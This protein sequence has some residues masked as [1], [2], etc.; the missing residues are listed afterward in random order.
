MN[1]IS[2]GSGA[3]PGARGRRPGTGDRQ[4]REQ[5]LLLHVGGA[6]QHQ[7]RV[8]PRM[9]RGILGALIW[10]LSENAV[11]TRESM[12]SR[13]SMGPW[14]RHPARINDER[15]LA[16]RNAGEAPGTIFTSLLKAQKA[17]GPQWR[18]AM[19]RST[20]GDQVE[21]DSVGCHVVCGV[22]ADAR[23]ERLHFGLAALGP[24][25]MP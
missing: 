6:E 17:S 10:R 23:A 9:L 16:Q 18:G 20:T 13:R 14:C 1:S 12:G 8:T 24:I 22:G 4:G 2:A 21:S 19:S 25:S 5:V 11:A 15:P 7:V 3:S